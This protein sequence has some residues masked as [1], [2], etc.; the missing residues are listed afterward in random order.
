MLLSVKK[1]FLFVFLCP[2]FGTP[3]SFIHRVFI[4]HKLCA[5]SPAQRLGH[6]SVLEGGQGGKESK[7]A[8]NIKTLPWPVYKGTK[9]AELN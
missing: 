3:H 8:T 6:L 5:R 7:S 1:V 9:Q 4:W 2:A